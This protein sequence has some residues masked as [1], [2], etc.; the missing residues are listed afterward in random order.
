M[1]LLLWTNCQLNCKSNEIFLWAFLN[2]APS[3][4]GV[5]TCYV[6][7]REELPLCQFPCLLSRCIFTSPHPRTDTFAWH[8][9][10]SQ[11]LKS[12][13]SECLLPSPVPDNR[14]LCKGR[15]ASCSS[16]H[17]V[18]GSYTTGT[19]LI[20]IL[21]RTTLFAFHNEDTKCL[22]MQY[23]AVQGYLDTPPEAWETN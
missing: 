4:A 21:D 16:S 5:G 2:T 8:K 22:Q 7:W 10:L 18:K 1:S 12:F 14:L 20:F 9:R 19:V 3:P 17:N 11:G 15:F 13:Y 6:S 23:G